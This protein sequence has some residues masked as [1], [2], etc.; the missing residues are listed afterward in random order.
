MKT[1]EQIE[2]G[3]RRAMNEITI[4]ARPQVRQ[5]AAGI[6]AVLHWAL[7]TYPEGYL[8]E[9]GKKLV[10]SLDKVLSDPNRN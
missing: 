1:H 3:I 9:S 8:A 7:G 6:V 2:T 5:E 4:G 10:D